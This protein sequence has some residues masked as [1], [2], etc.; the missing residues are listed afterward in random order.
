M[1]NSMHTKLVILKDFWEVIAPLILDKWQMDGVDIANRRVDCGA[2]HL[3][4]ASMRSR[5]TMNSA[6]QGPWMTCGMGP[7]SSANVW[8]HTCAHTALLL[9]ATG[10]P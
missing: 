3:G 10:L 1:L 4:C 5:E 8:S 6:Q 2:T 7:S 9:C